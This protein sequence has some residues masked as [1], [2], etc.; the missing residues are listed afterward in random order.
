MINRKNSP[1]SQ[2]EQNLEQHRA[3]ERIAFE[4]WNAAGCP[5]GDALCFWLAAENE[6]KKGQLPSND[7]NGTP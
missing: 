2:H 1:R 4:R 6:W 7:G 3:I 5:G